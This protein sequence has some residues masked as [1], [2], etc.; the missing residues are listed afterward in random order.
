MTG[1]NNYMLFYYTIEKST[2][3]C[4]NDYIKRAGDR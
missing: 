4:Y 2:E 3:V 1:L